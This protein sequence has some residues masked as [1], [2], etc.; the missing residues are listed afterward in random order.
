MGSFKA[1]QRMEYFLLSPLDAAW[2]PRSEFS[3]S[4]RPEFGFGRLSTAQ[5]RLR[6]PVIEPQNGQTIHQ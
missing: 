3:S 4:P 2:S 5:P 1:L 6:T